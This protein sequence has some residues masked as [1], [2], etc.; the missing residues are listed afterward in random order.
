MGRKEPATKKVRRKKS[1]VKGG[2]DNKK[3]LHVFP[4]PSLREESLPLLLWEFLVVCS[5]VKGEGGKAGEGEGRGRE[6]TIA[7]R[8]SVI[9]C[10]AVLMSST[11][12][13]RDCYMRQQEAVWVG[14]PLEISGYRSA[15]CAW[16]ASPA[17][18]DATS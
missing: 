11:Y 5:Q 16:G 3:E 17:A 12:S 15:R 18:P 2:V 6:R 8:L 13:R 9:P 4:C 10:M 14:L 7:G 1:V